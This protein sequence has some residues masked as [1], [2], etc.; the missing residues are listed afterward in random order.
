MTPTGPRAAGGPVVSVV[1]VCRNE[2]ALIGRTIGCVAAQSLD[3]LE[4]IVVD[5]ASGDASVATARDALAD[6]GRAH[7]L[8][9]LPASLGPAGARNAGVSHARGTYVAFLDAGDEWLTDK[10]ARQVG[11][12]AGDPG[13]TLCGCQAVWREEPRGH[14][15]RLFH[16]LPPAMR[17]GW[18]RLLWSRFITPAT[19]MARREDLGTAPFDAALAGDAARGLWFH[20]ASNG[21]VA[22]VPDVLVRLGTAA[23]GAQSHSAEL[24]R[25]VTRPMVLRHVAAFSDVLTLRDKLRAHAALQG[26]LGEALCRSPHA[27]LR[28]AIHLLL[29]GLLGYRPQAGLAE[30]VRLAPPLRTLRQR[31]GQ[32]PAATP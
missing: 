12:M 32:A 2:A 11:V 18:R 10:L 1:I 19:A 17:D 5:D 23:G 20:L 16:E 6:C 27:Y 13:V 25:E 24:V 3:D 14:E 8:L 15:R 31:R 26:E 21:T 29:A 9:E 28:G 4:I 30:M 7:S 22:L